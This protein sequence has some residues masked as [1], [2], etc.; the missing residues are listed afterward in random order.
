MH[1]RYGTSKVRLHN[2]E[3]MLRVSAPILGV[4]EQSKTSNFL[5]FT[6]WQNDRNELQE[7]LPV[8]YCINLADPQMV[9]F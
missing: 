1:D 5:Y 2:I 7:D 3:F 4:L 9:E 8:A 6:E